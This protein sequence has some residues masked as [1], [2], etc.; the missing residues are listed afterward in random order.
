[1]AEACFHGSET[2]SGFRKVSSIF[3]VRGICC[4]L[5]E[6]LFY[7]NFLEAG[8][9]L[10][11]TCIQ[12]ILEFVGKSGSCSLWRH[13]IWPSLLCVL[14][15]VSRT[16]A[17]N[18]QCHW[19]ISIW[20]KGSRFCRVMREFWKSLT[21]TQLKAVTHFAVSHRQTAAAV[22]VGQ[23]SV[24]L[25]DKWNSCRRDWLV[26]VTACLLTTHCWQWVTY[27]SD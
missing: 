7:A 6:Y 20:R 23:Q 24:S 4:D 10:P 2:S 18:C 17:N 19:L 26:C 12:H 11:Y 5:M 15:H 9:L 27:L 21:W 13:C 1:M 22:A 3:Q 16:W 8:F 14:W 25:S